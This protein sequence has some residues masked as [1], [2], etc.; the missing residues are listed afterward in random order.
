MSDREQVKAWAEQVQLDP[1]YSLQISDLRI[2][3]SADILKA[4]PAMVRA[5]AS[6]MG[7]KTK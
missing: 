1:S 2:K 4:D 3:L 7:I 5:V 6:T